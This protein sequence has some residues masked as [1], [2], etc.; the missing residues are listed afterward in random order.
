MMQLTFGQHS[1]T[2][3]AQDALFVAEAILMQRKQPDIDLPEH[4][5]AQHG[6]IRLR[7]NRGGLSRF[8]ARAP[9]PLSTTTHP[10]EQ[11]DQTDC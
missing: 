4:R 9:V 8:R 7:G 10:A 2:L 1:F 3:D 11:C 5:S 6:V